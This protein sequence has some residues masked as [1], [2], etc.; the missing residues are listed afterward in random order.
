VPK[1]LEELRKMMRQGLDTQS[2]VAVDKEKEG[3]HVEDL[4][5]DMIVDEEV[6]AV[7]AEKPKAFLDKSKFTKRARASGDF[8]YTFSPGGGGGKHKISS[9]GSDA[10]LLFGKHSG[11]NVSDLAREEP[12][13]LRWML[14]QDFPEPLLDVIRHV[15]GLPRAKSL[16]VDEFIKE[17]TR[18]R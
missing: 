17:R 14:G 6:G 18:K 15:L 2:T 16:A 12:G 11:K 1:T 10:L 5:S 9:D 13:Y 3:E 7:S 8:S 4:L